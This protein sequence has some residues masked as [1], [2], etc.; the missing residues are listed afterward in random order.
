MQATLDCNAAAAPEA[1]A[2]KPRH[3]AAAGKAGR[4]NPAAWLRQVQAGTWPMDTP[5]HTRHMQAA[6]HHAA[7]LQQRGRGPTAH[8]QGGATCPMPHQQA[9]ARRNRHAWQVCQRTSGQHRVQACL[10]VSWPLQQCWVWADQPYAAG[11]KAATSCLCSCHLLGTST[12]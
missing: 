6:A 9:L 12:C 11:L 3:H 1:G 5:L 8:M 2:G 10:P 7:P 4:C